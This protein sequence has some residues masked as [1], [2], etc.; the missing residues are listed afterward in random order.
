MARVSVAVA[1][2][3]ILEYLMNMKKWGESH[4]SHKSMFAPFP[5]DQRGSREVKKAVKELLSEGKIIIKKTTGEYHV[6]LNH[7]L[8]DDI[9]KEVNIQILNINIQKENVYKGEEQDD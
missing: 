9:K 1:R 6:S 8:T 7:H 2:K 3:K 4:T 5:K